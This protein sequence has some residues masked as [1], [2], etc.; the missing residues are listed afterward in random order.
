MQTL[1]AAAPEVAS[2]GRPLEE[3]PT[4]TKAKHLQYVYTAALEQQAATERLNTYRA[5]ASSPSQGPQ[6]QSENSSQLIRALAVC[7]PGAMAYIN[8]AT[9]ERQYRAPNE[10]FTLMLRRSLGMSL[11]PLEAGLLLN[12]TRCSARG[13]MVALTT[14]HL[15]TCQRETTRRHNAV[16]DTLHAMFKGLRFT[17]ELEPH[18][19]SGLNRWDICVAN[20]TSDGVKRFYD[21]TI[22]D[23][24]KSIFS[25][26]A[27]PFPNGHMDPLH[28]MAIKAKLAHYETDLKLLRAFPTS[29]FTVLPF[30]SFG[31]ISDPVTRIL[32][33]TRTIAGD[34]MCPKA[35]W[36]TGSVYTSYFAAACSFFINYYTAIGV[37]ESVQSARRSRRNVVGT[38][39][40]MNAAPIG[41]S[42]RRVP[43]PGQGPFHSTTSVNTNSITLSF[44]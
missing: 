36:T 27:D 25:Q 2:A 23:P 15:S 34:Y 3:A 37:S 26:A 39:D 13:F 41:T 14:Q 19:P 43:K 35:T 21:L 9:H 1:E 6:Q 7:E 22:V 17:T 11:I 44:Q 31:G 8:V 24:L 40:P 18:T 20:L 16:R 38:P 29:S 10:L 12:C 33:I 4:F 42:A 32:D 5:A 30:S 28:D